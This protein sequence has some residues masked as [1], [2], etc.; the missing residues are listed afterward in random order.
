[1]LLVCTW[2]CGVMADCS[3]VIQK[4]TGSNLG[5][6]TSG[7]SLVL[8]A[9]VTKQYN[10]IQADRRWC[11]YAGKVTAGL[12]ESNGSLPSGGW[13]KV[14]CELTACKVDDVECIGSFL[15]NILNS[16]GL[17]TEP[18]G[19][20]LKTNIHSVTSS[21]VITLCSRSVSWKCWREKVSLEFYP[22]IFKTRYYLQQR[23]QNNIQS[24]SINW[25]YLIQSSNW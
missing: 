17:R 25:Y 3:P 21:Y 2:K 19:K 16:K 18:C 23:T 15:M 10:L 12:V 24:N 14:T 13:L 4:V 1:M 20:P 5:Q 11:L 9:Y 8:A 22:A 7:N 6:S